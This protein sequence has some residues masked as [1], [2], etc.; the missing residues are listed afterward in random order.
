M[1]RRNQKSKKDMTESSERR[2]SKLDEE[3]AESERRTE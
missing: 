2:K 1:K 3:H